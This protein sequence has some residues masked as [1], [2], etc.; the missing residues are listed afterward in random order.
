MRAPAF[1]LALALALACIALVLRLEQ[2]GATTKATTE[3]STL[4]ARVDPGLAAAFLQAGAESCLSKVRWKAAVTWQG[5]GL[6]GLFK[7]RCRV[8]R[9]MT[10]CQQLWKTYL[11]SLGLGRMGTPG[12]NNKKKILQAPRVVE[13]DLGVRR[14]QR[15]RQ[16]WNGLA[17]CAIGEGTLS[18]VISTSKMAMISWL[19]SAKL[20]AS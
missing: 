18:S 5:R 16:H 8:G 20:L 11:I 9:N 2:S 10:F 3:A 14:K 7:G 17:V 13:R 15:F 6:L 19:A 12:N 1:V 4:P